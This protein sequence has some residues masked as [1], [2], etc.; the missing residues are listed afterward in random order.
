MDWLATSRSQSRAR[1]SGM[2]MGRIGVLGVGFSRRT[3]S[4]SL[5]HTLSGDGNTASKHF[6]GHKG[7]F[8]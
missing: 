5:D 3:C 6:G 2:G 7:R 8:C 1:G 4:M